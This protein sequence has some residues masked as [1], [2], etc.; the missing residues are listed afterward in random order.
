MDE[1]ECLIDELV[2]AQ[3][4]LELLARKMGG[5]KRAKRRIIKQVQSQLSD[6]YYSAKGKVVEKKG[7]SIT[8][9]KL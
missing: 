9:W 5:L 8:I 7:N 2:E 3:I 6:G 1:Q 4:C